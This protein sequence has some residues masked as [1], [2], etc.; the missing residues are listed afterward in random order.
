M[1]PEARL[2][3]SGGLG[4]TDPADSIGPDDAGAGAALGGTTGLVG[5]SDEG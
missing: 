1:V 3:G 2:M 4:G 5:E